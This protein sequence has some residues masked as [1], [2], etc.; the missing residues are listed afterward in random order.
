MLCEMLL[1]ARIILFLNKKFDVNFLKE[2]SKIMK[3]R[4]YYLK[5]LYLFLTN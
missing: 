1:E 5:I 3:V 2:Y 4:F